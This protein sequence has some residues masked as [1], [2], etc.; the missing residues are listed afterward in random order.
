MF[1]FFKILFL[2]VILNSFT[3][4]P[5]YGKASFYHDKFDGRKTA[6][7]EIFRQSKMTAACNIFPLGTYLKVT[8]IKNGKN[9][10]VKVNDRIGT[11]KRIIDLSRSAAIELGFIKYG[12]TSVKLEKID[13]K[14]K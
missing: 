13:H 2:F 9:V 3:D 4:D 11:D 14:N 10:I 1:R 12:I 6:S 8:N 7:G 5:R